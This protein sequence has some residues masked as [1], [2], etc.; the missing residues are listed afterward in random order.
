MIDGRGDHGYNQYRHAA[1]RMFERYGMAICR[2][3]YERLCDQIVSGRN[4]PLGLGRDGGFVRRLNY[5][6]REVYAIFRPDTKAI[7]TFLPAGRRQAERAI[8]I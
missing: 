8:Q 1:K 3:E 6:G 2:S 7:A 4:A 5:R